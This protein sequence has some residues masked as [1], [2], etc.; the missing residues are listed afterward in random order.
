MKKGQLEMSFSASQKNINEILSRNSIYHIAKNQRKYVWGENEWSELYEDLFLIPQSN[1]YKHFL[2]SLVFAKNRGENEYEI[3][4]GQQRLITLCILLSAIINQLHAINETQTALAFKQTYLLGNN[5]GNEYFRIDRDDGNFYLTEL[6]EN[7]NK[8]LSDIDASKLFKDNYERNDK[9]N[10]RIFNCYKYYDEKIRQ[11]VE[12]KRQKREKLILMKDQIINCEIIEINVESDTDGFRVF[13]TL[14]A[15]GIPLEQHELLKNYL[16]SYIRSDN[17][18]KKLDQKWNKIIE[19]VST[20]STDGLANFLSHYCVHLYGKTK[21]NEEFKTIRNN[22]DKAKVEELLISLYK[23]SF[24][25]S[26]FINPDKLGDDEKYN[27]TVGNALWF[28]KDMNIRQVR[29][30]LLSLFEK[31]NSNQISAEHFTQCITLLENFYFIYSTVLNNTTNTIDSAIISLSQEI[32]K[33]SCIDCAKLIRLELGR[34]ISEKK[35]IKEQFTYIGYSNKN[36]KFSNSANKKK[37][38]YI[39]KKFEIY[40]GCTDEMIPNI[41]SIEHIANDSETIDDHSYIG[42]LLPLATKLNGKI[43]NK[44]FKEKLEYYRKSLFIT[45]KRFISNYSMQDTWGNEDIEKRGKKMADVA[46]K[47]IWLF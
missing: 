2:G 11:V 20:S 28:F 12:K 1:H 17:A 13:E 31:Y 37:V 40:Y 29:P 18:R 19:N 10:E 27:G 4:D 25:Y 26:Y 34:Y 30:L 46:F 5:N 23:N 16:Y 35:K 21:K 32:N 45:V 39:F 43:G 44:S 24:Y 3:I 22:T 33:N 41:S 38:N 42:N 47:K 6:I 15:R 9:Y 8:Y 36:K 7:N 14:N